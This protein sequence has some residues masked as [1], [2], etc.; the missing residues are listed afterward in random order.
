M[1]I[2]CENC[3]RQITTWTSTGWREGEEQTI[4][5]HWRCR[6]GVD[7]TRTIITVEIRAAIL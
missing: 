6:C 1:N 3:G 4:T 5:L 7:G 2:C